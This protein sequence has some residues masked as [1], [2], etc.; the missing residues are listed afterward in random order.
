[1][2]DQV[3]ASPPRKKRPWLRRFGALALALLLLIGAALMLAQSPPAKAWLAKQMALTV[4]K[5]TG[6]EVELRG[7]SG[8]LPFRV[9]LAA[10]RIADEEGVF[11]SLDDATVD[12]SPLALIR[13]AV[14][15]REISAGRLTMERIPAFPPRKP[16]PEPFRVPEPPSPPQ[17]FTLDELRIDELVIG[18]ALAGERMVFRVAGRAVPAGES[19]DAELTITRTGEAVTRAH[20]TLSAAASGLHMAVD[21]DDATIAPARGGFDGPLVVRFEG[22]G[23]ASAWRPTFEVR[24]GGEDLLSLAESQIDLGPPLVMSGTVTVNTAHPLVVASAAEYISGPARLA[25]HLS[26]TPQ[27]LLRVESAQL[28]A[29]PVTAGLS[30]DF[31]IRKQHADLQG[32]AEHADLRALLP[33]LRSAIPQPLTLDIAAKGPIEALV[34]DAKAHLAGNPAWAHQFTLKLTRPFGVQGDF[35]ASPPPEVAPSAWAPLFEGGA[36]GNVSATYEPPGTLALDRLELRAAGAALDAWGTANLSETSVDMHAAFTA[37]S[38]APLEPLAGIPLAGEAQTEVHIV[39]GTDGITAEWTLTGEHWAA[40]GARLDFVEINAQLRAGGDWAQGEP[41]DMVLSASGAFRG[42]AY[43]GVDTQEHVISVELAGHAPGLDAFFLDQLD[44]TGPG[45]AMEAQGRLH[46]ATR[47]GEAAFRLAAQDLARALGPFGLAMRGTVSLEGNLTFDAEAPA[48]TLEAAGSGTHLAGLPMD[49]ER[50]IGDRF[51]LDVAAEYAASMAR[52]RKLHF[53][54][55]NLTAEVRGPF[56]LDEGE[57]ALEGVITVKELAP[58]A[59]FAGRPLAGAVDAEFTLAGT[60]DALALDAKAVGRGLHVDETRLDDVRIAAALAGLPGRPTGAVSVALSAAGQRLDGETRFA[61]EQPLLTVEA[62]ALRSG[63]NRVD[64]GG[65]LN[66]DT[67]AGAGNFTAALPRL[68][69][70]GALLGMELGGAI[71]LE[72]TFDTGGASPN[73]TADAHAEGVTTPWAS[74]DTLGLALHVRDPLGPAEVSM[75][76]DA[77]RFTANGHRIEKATINAAGPLNALAVSGAWEGTMLDKTVFNGAFDATVDTSG[78]AVAI[79]RLEGGFGPYPFALH[80]P[81]R[82][83]L[84]EGEFSAESLD[85]RF[86]EGS[87]RAT[88]GFGPAEVAFRAEIDAFPL[89]V[90]GYLGGPLLDGALSGSLSLLGTPREPVAEAAMQIVDFALLEG[91]QDAPALTAQLTARVAG[92]QAQAQ[93]TVTVP[94]AGEAKAVVS[95]PVEFSLAP[96]N[97]AAAPDAPITGSLDA[98]FDLEP[99][100]RALGGP[101]H[102]AAGQMQAAMRLDGTLANPRVRGGMTVDSGRYEN[103]QTGTLLDALTLAIDAQGGRIVLRE[104]RATD[105]SEGRLAGQGHLELREDFPFEMDFTFENARVVHRDDVSSRLSGP[106]RVAGDRY[107]MEVT[108]DLVVGPALLGMPRRSGPPTLPQAVVTEINVP[109]GGVAEEPGTPSSALPV[110]NLALTVD[111]PRRIYVRAPVLDSEWVGKL[112]IRGTAQAPRIEGL[113]RVHKGDLDFLGREFDLTGSTL[114]FDGSQDIMPYVTVTGRAETRTITG[115]LRIT[116]KPDALQ[117][118][119][120]SEPAVPNDEILARL[121]FGR[122]VTEITPAQAVQ[123][124]RVAMLLNQGMGGETLLSGGRGLGVV[125][126]FNVGAGDDPGEAVVGVGTYITDGIY[127]EIQT[128]T[129]GSSSSRVLFEFSPS[130]SAEAETSTTG[131]QGVSVFWKKDY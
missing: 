79:A 47:A 109:G 77:S 50:L 116:G 102:E 23:P 85:L 96:M 46:A 8:W 41:R 20:L 130:F 11:F 34:T 70:L 129:G 110:I 95:L 43:P 105:G 64:G 68:D 54:A 128:G 80:A 17:W 37:P 71:D 117:F 72:A 114:S 28:D 92:G 87:L 35:E 30:G 82:L 98:G 9:H 69:E 42:A 122:S 21:L 58:F 81:T 40:A 108:G 65:T 73:V 18:E 74:L 15:L 51:T 100:A 91:P 119:L 89:S 125:D 2:N 7:L 118:T 33:R 32:R 4:T 25:Y 93:A 10:L 62:L 124:A 97:L 56:A 31:D 12:W 112:S 13:G 106:L 107:A 6:Y 59:P 48:A 120:D 99:L 75:A 26:L 101:D 3:T 66:L 84:R 86:A 88:G 39:G 123:L 76:L 104:L 52:V 121:L 5:I 83:T 22:A 38:L 19:L 113:L 127:A 36:E 94:E 27:G 45:L 103:A 44:V 55:P 57:T 90:A 78:P 60:P 115:I 16:R 61:L 111:M 131:H 29:P 49:A 24:T 53:S 67:R 14:H 126:R 1:M 63:E